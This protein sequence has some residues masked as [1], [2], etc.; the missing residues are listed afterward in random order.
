MQACTQYSSLT[1]SDPVRFRCESCCVSGRSGRST[2]SL[3]RRADQATSQPGNRCRDDRGIDSDDTDP[4]AQPAAPSP[5]KGPK[6][7]GK[8]GAG[9]GKVKPK[10]DADKTPWWVEVSKRSMEEA[11]PKYQ[12]TH[13]HT[14]NNHASGPAVS[15]LTTR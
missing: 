7:G 9:K 10:G 15:F 2:N 13:V 4:D 12:R 5:K 6:N 14:P 3:L 11:Q 1:A 8:K